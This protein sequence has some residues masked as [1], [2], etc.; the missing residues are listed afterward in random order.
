MKMRPSKVLRKLRAGQPVVCAKFNLADPRAV[1]IGCAYGFDCAWMDNEHVPTDW[2]LLENMVRAAKIHDTDAMVRVSRGS[3]SDYVRP[4][5]MDAAGIMVPH[6][7]SAAEARQVVRMTKFHPVGRRP[8]DGGNLDGFFCQIPSREYI[9]QANRERFLCIQIEDPE[10]LKEL[11]EIAAVPG[12]D[13]LLF[14]AGDFAHAIGKLGVANAPE[15]VAAR[16]AVAQ[17]A[18][19][20]GKWAGVL[21]SPAD[22][23]ARREEGF[24][25]ISVGADVIGLCLYFE[26]L[27]RAVEKLG[28]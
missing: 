2:L 20:H 14:G 7:M 5:E 26:D 18:K 1:E 28:V 17:A 13:I 22:I 11:D 6:L 19:R 16:R 3:Y 10:A 23:P 24:Q 8:I 21:A 9:E 15:V 4:L 25:F 27:A 12:I